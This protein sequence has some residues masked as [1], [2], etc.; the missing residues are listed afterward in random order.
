MEIEEDTVFGRRQFGKRLLGLAGIAAASAAGLASLNP[1]EAHAAPA[2]PPGT[3]NNITINTGGLITAGS[4]EP[5]V[6]TPDV[7]GS[8]SS[9]AQ[10]LDGLEKY[11]GAARL[12]Q[13]TL[14]GATSL[15]LRNAPDAAVAGHAWV[16][17]DPYTTRCEF[18]RIATLSEEILTLN[19]PLAYAHSGQ[20]M[21]L[22]TAQP[23]FSA[24]LFGAKGNGTDLDHG[25]VQQA[26]YAAY[27][28]GGG[29]VVFPPG[30]YR[31]TQS[32]TLCDKV[33]LRGAGIGATTLD[34]S[35]VTTTTNYSAI[36]GEGTA[37]GL[38][39]LA[40]DALENTNSITLAI[41]PTGLAP[42]DILILYN[43]T[44]SS[45]NAAQ[46][47]YRQGEFVRVRAVDGATIYLNNQLFDTY[48]GGTYSTVAVEKINPIRTSISGLSGRF[49]PDLRGIHIEKG[50]AC[51]LTNLDL[52][53]SRK[54][55]IY[56]TR[57]FE[58]EVQ[59]IRAIDNKAW[60]GNN[61]GI[62]LSN[63]QRIMVSDCHFESTKHG[64]TAGGDGAIDGI[65]CREVT[66]T[67][68]VLGSI[69]GDT[70][71]AYSVLLHGNC[72]YWVISGCVLS[73]GIGVSGDHVRVVGCDIRSNL[74]GVAV[75][76][77][78]MLGLDF[79]I[80]DNHLTSTQSGT[81]LV[82]IV[83]KAATKRTNRV[84]RFVNNTLDLRTFVAPDYRYGGITAGLHLDLTDADPSTKDNDIVI[85]G[86]TIVSNTTPVP[87][88]FYGIWISCTAGRSLR[89]VRITDNTL[90]RCGIY[91][92]EVGAQD[93]LIAGN[94]VLDALGKGIYVRPNSANPPIYSNPHIDCRNN[95]VRRAQDTG[96]HIAVLN[97]TQG[98][99]DG[100]LV[101]T[102]NVSLNNWQKRWGIDSYE[103]GSIY[104]RNVRDLLLFDNI[105]GDNQ[106]TPSQLRTIVV[107]NAYTM[108]ERNNEIVGRI[109]RFDVVGVT[110][111][112]GR[113][114]WRGQAQHTHAAGPPT[115]GTW[116]TGDLVWNSAPTAGGILG[117]VC[118]AAGTPG[119]W[120]AFGKI[121]P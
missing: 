79:Q 104:I 53:G 15:P 16:I 9:L 89:S 115:A 82:W 25:A 57:C 78:E 35:A 41:A 20:A 61:Y 94:Q 108:H 2:V 11:P 77:T 58:S 4:R 113:A 60:T 17:L 46:A 73:R 93:T 102:G 32:L 65:P 3:Y 29:T 91:V 95:Q 40:A 24:L 84:F 99:A 103:R 69:V 68:C 49:T 74:N 107:Y 72:E 87:G 34:L 14:A 98:A 42:G 121:A 37:T 96:I 6:R 22:F 47:H 97:N 90:R 66:V 48:R 106:P 101:C 59:G 85:D 1:D 43:S 100:T 80:E 38:G 116:V 30:T 45:F 39:R 26:I 36:Y 118:V 109:R 81:Q 62:C 117:W 76:G 105:V 71:G 12:A 88:H 64:L 110:N 21:V 54:H 18:R 75:Y 119:I 44:E 31:L 120:K 8:Y 50:A 70:L 92:Q 55:N 7:Q 13:G 5:Y 86:N 114:Q 28:A 51:H 23:E 27:A 33:H 63:C 83:P 112:V 111:E 56:L 52:T 19:R 10:R 67:N